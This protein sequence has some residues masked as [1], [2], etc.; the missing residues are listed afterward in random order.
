MTIIDSLREL[1][2]AER[3]Q[4]V[5]DLWDSIEA[6]QHS[7]E[8]TDAQRAELDRRLQL[9]AEDPDDVATWEDV[10]ARVTSSRNR[11]R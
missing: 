4:L 1:S 8:L 5:Q 2:V 9:H 10:K 3:I 6:D 11:P 7:M